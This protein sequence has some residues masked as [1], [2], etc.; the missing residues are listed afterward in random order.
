MSGFKLADRSLAIGA[1]VQHHTTDTL[2]NLQ[3]E[4]HPN[5]KPVLGS[6]LGW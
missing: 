4:T 2:I 6:L 1:S 3:I 5:V